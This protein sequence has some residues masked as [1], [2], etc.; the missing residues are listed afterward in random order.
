M[1]GSY[2]H[3]CAVQL[4]QG[5]ACRMPQSICISGHSFTVYDAAKCVM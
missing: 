5:S 4:K 1:E 3:L 2:D